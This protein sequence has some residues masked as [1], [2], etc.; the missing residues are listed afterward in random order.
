MEEL[1]EKF[2]LSLNFYSQEP[3]SIYCVRQNSD[4]VYTDTQHYESEE[5]GEGFYES[6][7]DF[8]KAHGAQYSLSADVTPEKTLT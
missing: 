6:P 1:D 4:G 3:D 5:Y 2:R 8:F 7:A